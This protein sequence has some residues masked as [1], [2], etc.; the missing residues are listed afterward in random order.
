VA[1][2]P[3]IEGYDFDPGEDL[4]PGS[5]FVDVLGLEFD[6]LSPDRVEAHLTV[7]DRLLQPYGLVH[8]GVYA[9]V[10]ETLGSVAGALRVRA[11]G[12]AVVGVHNS[13]DFLRSI[14]EGTVRAVCTPIHVGRSQHLW[15]TE[16]RDERGR[17]LA[18]GQLRVHVLPAD[19]VQ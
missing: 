13:T 19:R 5:S 9:S 4:V 3:R 18:R 11:G 16:C 15:L 7:T 10:V 6:L 8:G 14:R 12:E 2:A 17:L 1:Q